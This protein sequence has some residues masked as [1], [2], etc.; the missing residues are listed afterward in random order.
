MNCLTLQR[1]RG[2]RALKVLN[3]KLLRQEFAWQYLNITAN[4]NL[5]SSSPQNSQ[6]VSQSVSQSHQFDV[7]VMKFNQYSTNCIFD[8]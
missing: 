3:Y 2:E 8:I 1:G 7:S 4:Y 6:S 5:R